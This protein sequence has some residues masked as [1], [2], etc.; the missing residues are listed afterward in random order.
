M[1]QRKKATLVAFSGKMGSGKDTA[2]AYLMAKLKQEGVST[3]QVSFAR[4][5]REH[6]CFL[7][8]QG[9]SFTL[10]VEQTFTAQD[11]AK[12][13]PPHA[14]GTS[15]TEAQAAFENMVSRFGWPSLTPLRWQLTR[16]ALFDSNEEKFQL[17]EFTVGRFLQVLGSDVARNVFDSA[18]WIKFF[19]QNLPLNK[20]FLI[21]TDLRLPNEFDY[22]CEK[23][24]ES[25][26]MN[27]Y[28]CRLEA[29]KR[30][31]SNTSRDGR[32]KTHESETG[33]DSIQHA[34]HGLVID[35]NGSLDQL[36]K[37]LD[38][39]AR[40]LLHKKKPLKVLQWLALLLIAMAAGLVLFL[41]PLWR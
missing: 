25:E 39:L 14:L 27:V 33:L 26:T 22:L 23:K 38:A 18:I 4:I 20:E 2:A 21:L 37:Q 11:K 41:L 15:E 32:A 17:K 12:I 5:L 1:A 40:K 36:Y 31:S 30:L 6:M 13:I 7:L 3:A 10:L 34:V 24:R 16:Q 29:Q 28:F 35:N 19:D 8:S 9:T